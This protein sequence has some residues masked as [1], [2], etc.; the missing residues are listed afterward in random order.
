MLT[1]SSLETLCTDQYHTL[2]RLF[3]LASLPLRVSSCSMF[4]PEMSNSSLLGWSAMCVQAVTCRRASPCFCVTATVSETA[5]NTYSCGF[6]PTLAHRTYSWWGICHFIVLI[7]H[8]QGTVWSHCWRICPPAPCA[9]GVCSSSSGASHSHP[10]AVVS[11]DVFPLLPRDVTVSA[12]HMLMCHLWNFFVVHF[13]WTP[14]LF[15]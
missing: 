7:Q 9:T 15:F 3:S 13:Q 8:S 11:Q 10:C 14:L 4:S 1:W 6:Q 2:S 5:V 12:F